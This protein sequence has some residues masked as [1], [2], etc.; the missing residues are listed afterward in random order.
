METVTVLRHS[1][2]PAS[3]GLSA[4]CWLF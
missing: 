1:L 3:R 4:D 2:A